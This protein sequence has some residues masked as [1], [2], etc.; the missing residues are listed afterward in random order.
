MYYK[1]RKVLL[2]TL[3]V[4]GVTQSVFSIAAHGQKDKIVIGVITQSQWEDK[5]KDSIGTFYGIN[6]EYLKNIADVL[7][8]QLELKT[9]PYIDPLLDD[10]ESGKIDGAVGFSKTPDR[11]ERF[12][13]SEPFFSSTIAVWYR[14]SNY[15]TIPAP[16]LSWACVEGSVYCQTLVKQGFDNIYFASTQAEA[17][18]T[19]ASGRANAL[20]STYVMINKYLDDND[21]VRGA[22]DVP[23]WLKEE[24]VS[25]ITSKDKKFLIDDINKILEWEKTGQNVR[26]VASKNPY[27]INDKLLLDYRRNDFSDSSITYSTSEDANP[28]LFRNHTGGELEGFLPDFLDLIQARTGLKFEYVKPKKSLGSGLTAFQADLVPVAYRNKTLSS[29]WLLTKPFMQTTYLAIKANKLTRSLAKNAKRGILVSLKKQGMIHLESWR[30]DDFARYDDLKNLL[31]DLK[32]GKISVAYVPDDIVHSLLVRDNAEGLHISEKDSLTFWVAFAVSKSNT[33]LKEILD[34]IIV[35]IDAKEIEKLSRAYRNFNLIYGYGDQDVTKM[36]GVVATVFLVLIA[37]G[38]FVLAHLRLKVN[39]AQVTAD[40]EEKERKWL[41]GII[42]EINSLVFIHGEDNKL[43][44]SNCGMFLSGDCKGCQIKA[45]ESEELLVDNPNELSSV[46]RGHN[47]ADSTPSRDCALGVSYVYRERKVI[48]APSSNK[49]FVLTV[50]QDIEEQKTRE[51]E[52]IDAQLEAQSAVQAREKFLATMSHELRTPLSAVHGLLDL[53]DG[54]LEEESNKGLV[55]QAIRSLNHLNTLVDEVLDYSKLDAGMLMINP[56]R[57]DWVSLV[58]DVLRSFEAKAES[59][60]LDYRVVI[61]PFAKRWVMVDSL[62][63]TQILTNLLSNAVKFTAEGEIAV[64]VAVSESNLIVKVIDTGIGM[65]ENQLNSIF[66][67]FVQADDSITRKYGG[68]GL[69]LSIVDRLVKC[70]RGELA[71]DSQIDLGTTIKVS[72][73]IELCDQQEATRFTQ[74][75]APTLPASIRK[76]CETWQ[77]QLDNL[78]ADVTPFNDE[79][80]TF[81]GLALHDEPMITAKDAKYP[82]ALFMLFDK[83]KCTLEECLAEEDAVSWKQGTLLVAED[84]PIN[85]S[86]IRMQ[87]NQLGITP[88]IVSS[89]QEAWEYLQTDSTVSLVLTDFH[90]PEMDGYELASRLQLHESLC[91]LPVI[92]VTAEDARLAS[93]KIGVS[94]ITDVLYKP[95]GLTEL[96]AMLLKYYTEQPAEK[97]SPTWLERFSGAEALEVA[98]VFIDSMKADLQQL[99]QS[100]RACETR[101]IIH[102]IKGALGAVGVSA[103]AEMCIR[104]EQSAESDFEHHVTGLINNIEQEIEHVESWIE[105]YEH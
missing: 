36:I 55:S 33:K 60:R 27:H 48:S 88:V 30:E 93:K 75:Y 52:L 57:T 29:E 11:L 5:L 31:A 17:F 99:K 43:K 103:I 70:M 64:H 6:L 87:L 68:T 1:L 32:A 59:K 72:L 58:S 16:H 39:L 90:M 92:G 21:I 79:H 97:R 7:D 37:V 85:Q 49:R 42:Q 73:P 51:Q 44:M 80:G 62:R 83:E 23:D 102:G 18:E 77:M 91:D 9:Y 25:F 86:V 3:A 82:D 94:G 56:Q 40:N 8:Y 28:F 12:L 50:L 15:K 61:R 34:S 47:I 26:S 78:H 104:A 14:N 20:I 10:I 101:K 4:F 67:P 19:V 45:S 81:A 98:R 71:I 54:Q 13:F 22:V 76:W 89:G 35:T 84:N 105:A 65:T 2:I 41:T 96:K 66:K 46:L 95:Y 24:E 100:T 74:T 69:G 53:L 63:L 38:Y